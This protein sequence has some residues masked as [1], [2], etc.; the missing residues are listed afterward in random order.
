MCWSIL[1]I[2]QTQ[3]GKFL[4]G[5][6]SKFDFSNLQTEWKSNYGNANGGKSTNFEV[7]P[8]IAYFIVENIAIGFDLPFN[9]SV[10][11]DPNNIKTITTSFA[12]APLIRAYYGSTNLKPFVQGE[13]GYGK[14]TLK[15][16][17]PNGT[18]DKIPESLF[19]YKVGGGLGIFFNQ[20][21]SLDFAFGYGSSYIKPKEN[22]PA[23]NRTKKDT[24]DF[25]IGF[26]LL[27]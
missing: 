8:K 22:N 25:L 3:K 13:I 19:L 15:N 27:F 4:I 20:N 24:F 6:G 14:Y 23:N 7:S 18:E 21:I 1:I 2:G 5:V 17:I 10:E 16:R 11:E 9:Y 26:S 12:V